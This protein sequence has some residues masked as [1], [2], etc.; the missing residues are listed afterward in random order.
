MRQLKQKDIAI[1]RL[2]LIEEQHGL[3]CLCNQIIDNP[4]LDHN[5]KTGLI[6]GVLCRGCNACLGIIENRMAMY[7]LTD[8][9]KLKLFLDNIIEYRKQY[10]E[11]IHPS[12]GKVKRRSKKVS[13][14]QSNK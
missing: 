2:E 11:M 10:Y 8:E 3:C 7:K 4:V 1:V 13:S 14:K 9:S 12:H 6:R 5:H